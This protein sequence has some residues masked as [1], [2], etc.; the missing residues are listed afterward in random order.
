MLVIRPILITNSVLS[1][2]Y[3]LSIR[4]QSHDRDHLIVASQALTH[5]ALGL[6]G[7]KLKPNRR[8]SIL[9]AWS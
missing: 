6:R 1:K 7:V 2:S 9:G 3:K 5:M 4:S 8:E